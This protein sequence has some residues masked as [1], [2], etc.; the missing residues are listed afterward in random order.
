MDPRRVGRT[1]YSARPADR[2]TALSKSPVLFHYKFCTTSSGGGPHRLISDRTPLC[3]RVSNAALRRWSELPDA[4]R[5]EDPDRNRIK[6]GRAR[7][8]LRKNLKI[9]I[10]NFAY[11]RQDAPFRLLLSNRIT[12]QQSKMPLSISV[13]VA[14]LPLAVLSKHPPTIRCCQTSNPT[15]KSNVRLRPP[16]PAMALNFNSLAD[17]F[18][19]DVQRAEGRPLNVPLIAPFTIASSRLDAVE[20]VAIRVE[21]SNGSVGWGEAPILPSVTAEDQATALQKAEEACSFLRLAEPASLSLALKA[22]GKLLPGHEFA[23]VSVY[24]GWIT[25][26][27]HEVRAGV[28]MALIDAVANSIRIP[29]W[30]LFGG[31]TDSITTDITIPIVSPTEAAQLAAKYAKQGFGTLKLKVGKNLKA[32]IEVLRAIRVAHPDCSF[33][34]DANEGYTADEAI[35]VLD[36]LHEM[37]VTPVLFEQPVHRDDWEGLRCVTNVAKDKYGTAIAADESCRSLVD[38]EKIIQGNFADVINFKLAKVGVLGAFEI[39]EVARSAGLALMIGGMVETRLA[40]GF[41]GHLAAGLGCFRFIDLDTPILLAQDP[42]IGGYEVSGAVYKFTNVRGHGGFLHWDSSFLLP[43]EVNYGAT[44]ISEISLTN[45]LALG[46]INLVGTDFGLGSYRFGENRPWMGL[47]SDP[48]PR[49]IGPIPPGSCY[50]FAMVEKDKANYAKSHACVL[51]SRF[52]RLATGKCL[53][54]AQEKVLTVLNKPKTK[55]LSTGTERHMIV[56]KYTP[57]GLLHELAVAIK[58]WTR[59]SLMEFIYISGVWKDYVGKTTSPGKDEGD[60]PDS[61]VLVHSLGPHHTIRPKC[62][63]HISMAMLLWMANYLLSSPLLWDVRLAYN[64]SF[65][66]TLRT[67][68]Y[69]IAADDA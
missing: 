6:K 59:L 52:K 35:E 66:T 30:K 17:T 27:T 50:F 51:S 45:T 16:T 4:I 56:W 33:I 68:H 63:I 7:K 24:L 22:V 5:R 53:R 28:E 14:S 8:E 1:E 12:L 26:I 18:T 3:T 46:H 23:S 49:G 69:R 2:I 48:M 25:K 61:N 38:V 10:F 57:T 64:F 41:A 36:K 20:N 9:Q 34:L 29:L 40:M 65:A 44:G 58:S 15:I 60:V 19:I 32:D 13:S 21:L 55:V 31:A 62:H 43:L 42:V 47:G 11:G 67:R 39:I 54:F 37:G